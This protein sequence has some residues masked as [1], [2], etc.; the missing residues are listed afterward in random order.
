MNSRQPVWSL[1]ASA[2]LSANFF[3]PNKLRWNFVYRTTVRQFNFAHKPRFKPH[4]PGQGDPFE[5]K[6]I[7]SS[8][9]KASLGQLNQFSVMWAGLTAESVWFVAKQTI[10]NQQEGAFVDIPSA[11]AV[12]IFFPDFPMNIPVLFQS[13]FYQ[14]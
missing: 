7:K 14:T 12:T 10:K 1:A 13:F 3:S 2:N 6:L 4:L 5:I 9:W 8:Q 11:V